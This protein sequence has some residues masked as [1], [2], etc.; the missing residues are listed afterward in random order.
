M[1]FSAKFVALVATTLMPMLTA[2]VQFTNNAYNNINSGQQY[3]LNWNGDGSNAQIWLEGTP[4]G[5]SNLV[6]V[7]VLSSGTTA[8][9]LAVTIPNVPSGTYAFKIKQSG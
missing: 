4:N 6:P 3:T 5:Q 9:T 2:A 7:A 8:N 1:Q